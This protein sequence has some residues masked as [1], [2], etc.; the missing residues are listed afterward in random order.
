MAPF[1]PE[2]P[3]WT[4]TCAG[5]LLDHRIPAPSAANAPDASAPVPGSQALARPSRR[6]A[7]RF[8]ATPKQ[9]LHHS[10]DAVVLHEG[11]AP[12]GAAVL[13]ALELCAERG[14]AGSHGGEVHRRELRTGYDKRLCSWQCPGNL[15]Y[16]LNGR[17]RKASRSCYDP[18]VKLGLRGETPR[19]FGLFPPAQTRRG[20]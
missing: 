6:S 4:R 2:W 7:G 1:A 11:I 18:F 17:L 20:I 3:K 12:M 16:G 5:S 15:R 19:V 9:E 13:P 14:T 10:G 8:E